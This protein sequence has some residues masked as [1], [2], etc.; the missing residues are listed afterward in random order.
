VRVRLDGEG[1]ILED[2]V[3]GDEQF[4]RQDSRRV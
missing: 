4:E 1:G 2:S 3:S